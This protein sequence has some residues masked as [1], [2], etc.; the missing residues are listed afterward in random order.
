MQTLILFALLTSS[1]IGQDDASI[2]ED[3]T[4]ECPS[5]PVPY[6]KLQSLSEAIVDPTRWD[7]LDE[8]RWIW[9]DGV[10][11]E[12]RFEQ[13][14]VH[15]HVTYASADGSPLPEEPDENLNGVSFHV[16]T[17]DLL[18]S[19]QESAWRSYAKHTKVIS[20]GFDRELGCVDSARS[21]GLLCPAGKTCML[22]RLDLSIENTPQGIL[23]AELED[24]IDLALDRVKPSVIE[25]D[26]P[27]D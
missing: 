9:H 5:E 24:A 19:F 10:S 2:A 26:D 15:Y 20:D 22:L 17:H 7:G 27:K 18:F 8:Y 14:D 1:A 12:V 16:Q 3:A 25:E 21:T 11:I 23:Q 4:E 6:W 13:D